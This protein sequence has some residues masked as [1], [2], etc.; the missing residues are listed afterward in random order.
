MEEIMILVEPF[1]NNEIGDKLI[2]YFPTKEYILDKTDNSDNDTTD[3]LKEKIV[4]G[5]NTF[6]NIYLIRYYKNLFN[7][8]KEKDMDK[9][10]N[11]F[12][13]N[14]DFSSKDYDSIKREFDQV[15]DK[16]KIK[17]DKVA[18]SG[19][20]MLQKIEN[21][22]ALTLMGTLQTMTLSQSPDLG[23]TC[24]NKQVELPEQICYGMKDDFN[25]KQ[26]YIKYKKKY[27]KY[28]NIPY[29]NISLDN[30]TNYFNKYIKYK[31][32]YHNLKYN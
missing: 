11:D 26:K 7:P 21:T 15:K 29:K 23:H 14:N 20:E 12:V 19:I 18:E 1:R 10:Y 31:K 16:L 22:N 17:P 6:D 13:D 5:I 4:E 28:K 3:K 27:F 24:L 2:P 9:K 8:G 25:I 30:N 32:K